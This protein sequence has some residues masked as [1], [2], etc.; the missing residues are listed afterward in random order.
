MHN[1]NNIDHF[2]VNYSHDKYAQVLIEEEKIS[3]YKKHKE[4]KIMTT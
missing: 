1:N 3:K 4:D 2:T